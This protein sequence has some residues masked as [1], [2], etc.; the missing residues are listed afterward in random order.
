MLCVC[1][2]CKDCLEEQRISWKA[3]LF[4]NSNKEPEGGNYVNSFKENQEEVLH[5]SGR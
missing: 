3:K 4:T 2:G 1:G 5:S